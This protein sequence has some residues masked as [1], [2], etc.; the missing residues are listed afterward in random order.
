MQK[1]VDIKLQHVYGNAI[2]LIF[3]VC[4]NINYFEVIQNQTKNEVKYYIC[5][6]ENIC[7]V[8]L[9][10]NMSLHLP[11]CNSTNDKVH[12]LWD[13]QKA[14]LDVSPEHTGGVQPTAMSSQ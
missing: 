13:S 5:K 12:L 8:H 1:Y 4:K 3:H 11:T 6:Y 2:I 7:Y 14:W 9:T 10:S